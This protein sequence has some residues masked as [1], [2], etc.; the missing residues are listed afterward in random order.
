[1]FHALAPIHTRVHSSH[2]RNLR[3][4]HPFAFFLSA[5]G[6]RLLWEDVKGSAA[7]WAEA[8]YRKMSIEGRDPVDTETLHYGETGAVDNRKILVV[9]RS[10]DRPGDLQVRQ[11]NCFNCGDPTAQAF[12]KSLTS[13]PPNPVAKQRPCFDQNVIRRYQSF[14]RFQNLFRAGVAAV[15]GVR[16]GIPNRSVHK[17]AH[18]A[19]ALTTPRPLPLGMKSLGHHGILLAR[20]I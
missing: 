9:P 12:P 2:G 20:N 10:S 15:G 18:N 5:K 19:R 14:A 17:H 13:F 6:A 1:R 4:P 11:S 7:F 3:V 8:E 16:D